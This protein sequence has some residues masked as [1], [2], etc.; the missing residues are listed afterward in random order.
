M[1]A[2]LP[3]RFQHPY[4]FDKKYDMSSVYFCME[5]AID[6]AL[7]I[8][9][10]GLGFLAGS[11]MRSAY[12]LKQN[13][14][15][16]GILWS[17][18]YYDQVRKDDDTLGVQFRRKQYNFLED[19]GIKFQITIHGSPVW[20][21]AYFLN[22]ETF[23]TAPLFLLTTDIPEN[24][25]LARS[26]T[27]KL[28]DNNQA[29]KVA[30]CMVL[31]IG[32]FRL[33]EELG[34]TPD[35]YHINEAHALPIAFQLYEKYR[36]V[37]EV[38]KNLV[39]TTHT[40][41]EA[42]NEK[43]LIHFLEKMTF[44]GNLSLKEVRDITG[45]DGEL[46][47]HTLVALRLSRIANGVSKLHGE[48]ARNM[49]ASY[50]GICPIIHI[51]NTQNAMFWADS[52]VEV[53]RRSKD[54]KLLLE[55]KHE[56][57]EKLFEEVV[58]QTGKLYDPKVLTIVWAR[59]FAYYKRPDL[60][61][62]DIADLEALLNNKNYPVQIIWA[63][64]PYP[65]DQQAIDLFNQLVE[66]SKKYEGLAVLT[67]YELKLSKLLKDG[68]D[69]WLNTPIVTREASGTS[70]MTAAMN[71]GISLSTDDGWIRE[72]A[73]HGKN[74]FVIPVTPP[75]VDEQERDEAD[76]SA[77]FKIL[78]NEVLPIYY[79]KPSDW[80]DIML[81]SMDDVHDYFESSRMVDDYY[82][83]LY[84]ATTSKEQSALVQQGLSY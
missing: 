71:G 55:R 4:E 28:Y 19:T 36:S 23:G 11:H 13:K 66:L 43:H 44:F 18:G 47:N 62:R 29:A 40:P 38:K 82:K 33:L 53:A 16:I 64:K 48:V 34:Y 58:D 3:S 2:I 72:F 9:S 45:V 5:F 7:K 15:G 8:Y 56:L 24:N 65:L 80:A 67:G 1:S 17:Y 50:G 78:I 21:K 75:E 68:S 10:G 63:G 25:H 61:T 30:Q 83:L 60:I 79:N 51:T 14:I 37:D 12:E 35:V 49:W 59:R 52:I 69:I 84:N 76:R 32:G 73:K 6:Q 57:K 22:P 74:A 70:G 31:G 20:V 39:F 81:Q 46:F 42:G 26:T 41:E 77:I 27:H 54:K